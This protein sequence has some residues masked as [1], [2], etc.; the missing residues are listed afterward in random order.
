MK[1]RVNSR[2]GSA[3]LV[4][5]GML[6]FMVVSAVAFS[7]FMRE[8]R[9]PSSFLRQKIVSGHLVKAALAKAMDEIDSAIG[10]HPYPGVSDSS[11]GQ[12]RGRGGERNYWKNR[13][14]MGVSGEGLE[15]W[16]P[17]TVSPLTLEAL[18][19]LP[20]PLINTVRY[21][22][23]RTPTA[24]WHQLGYDAG[25]YAY[26][27]VNVSD[28]LDINRL[29]ANVMRDSSPSNRIS[30]AYLFENQQHTGPASGASPQKFDDF[31]K[32]TCEGDDFKTRLVSLADYNL[33]IKSG[34]YGDIGFE[35]PFCE[36]FSGNG[37]DGLLY[38]DVSL[39]TIKRQ[40]FVTD[41][42]YPG[43][44]TNNVIYL[45][46]DQ[47]FDDGED[48]SFER[49]QRSTGG[50]CYKRLRNQLDTVAFAALYDYVDKD[51]VPISLAIPT[52]ERAPMFT[53][54]NVMAGGFGITMEK[55]DVRSQRPAGNNQTVP[56]IARTWKMKSL[57]DGIL[58]V[59]AH[60]VYPFRRNSGRSEPTSYK[61]EVLVKAF[62]SS[63]DFDFTKT[64]YPNRNNN[65]KLKLR[66]RNISEWKAESAMADSQ[67]AW[68]TAVG[69]GRATFSESRDSAEDCKVN[70]S[71]N[72]ITIPG[73]AVEGLG[74]FGLEFDEG[75]EK[76][77]VPYL[78]GIEKPL[79]FYDS[80]GEIKSIEKALP[81]AG[82]KLNLAFWFRI[83]DGDGKTVDLVPATLADDETYNNFKSLYDEEDE[84]IIEVC[85]GRGEPVLPMSSS[86]LLT[87]VDLETF[88]ANIDVET[89][90]KADDEPTFN[91]FQIFCA[92]PRFNFAPEDWYTT[93]SMNWSSWLSQAK[94]ACNGENG[95][96]RDLF[97]F[98][99]DCGYLQSMGELQF[100]P[101]TAR[102][103]RQAFRSY[104]ARGTSTGF[105]CDY[106]KG[107]GKYNGAFASDISNIA[108]KDYVWRTHWAFGPY[109]DWASD[110]TRSP[111]MW[112]ILDTRDG[113]VVTPYSASD[114]LLMAG[115]ANTPYDWRVAGLAQDGEFTA[116][117]IGK[118]CFNGYSGSEAPFPWQDL[119]DVAAGMRESFLEG[120]G[121]STD[122]G[123]N[124]STSDT[125]NN[126]WYKEGEFFGTSNDEIDDVDR[127]YLYSYWKNCFGDRQQLFLVFV[128][129]EPSVLGGST[130]RTP[131]QMGARA[132]ALV[133]REPVSS[134]GE[135]SGGGVQ[136]HRMRILFY[137]QFE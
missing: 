108:N 103:Q 95:K 10:S 109:A 84:D 24:Q 8:N 121:W 136:A 112:G 2:K 124:R 64:R 114:D 59:A 21:W 51:S 49:L 55:S 105:D 9:L 110:R 3:L 36:Y 77:A 16:S 90:G 15:E 106:L 57:G 100:L 33:A 31:I 6:S 47:P 20:P 132:V 63:G 92:D 125:W 111:Y 67:K 126:Y 7:M 76:N 93:D 94:N 96:P 123:G 80:K 30:S 129:A 27:A 88:K 79:Y 98:V 115:L 128:R 137:H 61:V 38:G 43:Q 35:S 29:R 56:H 122:L 91:E 42:W 1:R 118:Y 26:A 107:A 44:A 130:G 65:I 113:A 14:F 54:L 83:V 120:E 53:G 81:S 5:L 133:W 19:Y 97:Q 116:S 73:N 86:P 135:S 46:D 40:Q 60:G 4:V 62:L 75:N 12:S 134:L 41:S 58:T 28:Y 74:V 50:E 18:A 102:N 127:R 52:I 78:D 32:R 99:S 17:D 87:A 34:Q 37:G 45:T 72:D 70:I 68:V 119:C 66:P 131:A 25:R 82:L 104:P 101:V 13:V 48:M 39:D 23:R 85:C 71:V 89:P 22:S 69:S 11:T 117:D